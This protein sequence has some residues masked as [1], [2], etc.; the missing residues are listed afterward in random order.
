MEGVEHVHSVS[1][2][3]V[4]CNARTGLQRSVEDGPVQCRDNSQAFIIE[5]PG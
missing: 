5:D 4:D 2:V 1:G 3:N